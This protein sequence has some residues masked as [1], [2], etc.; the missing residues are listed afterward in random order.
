MQESAAFVFKA[1]VWLFLWPLLIA[2]HV[3][4]WLGLPMPSWGESLIRQRKG[5]PTRGRMLH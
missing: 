1:A 3:V 2:M 5:P 4:S